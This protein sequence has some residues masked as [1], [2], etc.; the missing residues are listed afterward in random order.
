MIRFSILSC[1]SLFF[2]AFQATVHNGLVLA[3]GPIEDS[4][5]YKTV[6][7]RDLR[8]DWTRPAEWKQADNRAAV[9]FI[10]G[11]GWVGGAPGQFA[12]HSTE[13][14]EDGLVCFRIEYRLIPK[15]IPGPPFN[16]VS[17]VSDAFR[18]IRGHA[19][20]LGIDPNRIAAGGGSAGGHLSAYLGMMDDEVKEG[21]SR[22]PN[23]LLLF[24]PV[25]NN[26]P[27]QWGHKRVGDAYR[28]YSPAHNID[29]NDPPACVVLG[30]DDALIP[31]E[32]AEQFRDEMKKAGLDSRLFLY[33]GQPHGFFNLRASNG[34]FYRITTDRMKT[35]LMDH[36]FQ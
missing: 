35:F 11:G 27:G 13:L 18:Y 3:N 17:D 36:G 22:K 15:G 14:A 24:N 21:V 10:H 9:A 6:E 1:I 2:L 30:T 33:D 8:I 20:A 12:P 7:G 16:A 23:A 34:K 29:A 4:F 25:Y 19:D 28:D 32:I 31:V 26:G 5:I